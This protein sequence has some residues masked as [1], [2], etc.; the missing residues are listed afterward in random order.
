ME[1]KKQSAKE[2]L[3]KDKLPYRTQVIIHKIMKQREVRKGYIDRLKE[4]YGDNK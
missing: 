1:S 3:M 2:R 4:L